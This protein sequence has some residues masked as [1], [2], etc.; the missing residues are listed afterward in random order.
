MRAWVFRG[1]RVPLAFEEVPPPEPGRGEVRVCLAA[2]ALNHRDLYFL[3]GSME[4]RPGAILGSDGAGVICAVGE[5]VPTSR[6]GERVFVVP[7]LGWHE[8]PPPHP[9]GFASSACRIP[10]PLPRPWSCP[11]KT[12]YPFPA[13]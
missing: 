8:V 9:Q 5:G 12:P 6:V 10:G 3:E 13:A 7:S 1:A 2:S 4:A 11:K